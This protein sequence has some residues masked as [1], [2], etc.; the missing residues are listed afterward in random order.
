MYDI[1]HEICSSYDEFTV[2][3]LGILCLGFFKTQTPIRDQGLV[4]KLYDSVISEIA[5][6]N[7]MNLAAFLKVFLQI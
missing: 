1:E 6:I 5:N 4:K 7:S 2:K 3:E